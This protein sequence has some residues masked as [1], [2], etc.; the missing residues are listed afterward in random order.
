MAGPATG[1]GLGTPTSHGT[2]SRAGAPALQRRMTWDPVRGMTMAGPDDGP[3]SAAAPPFGAASSGPA[4][5]GSGGTA[6]TPTRPAIAPLVARSLDAAAP[7]VQ[8]EET[9][10]P[11][12]AAGATGATSASGGTTAAMPEAQL[13]DLARRLHEKIAARLSRDLLIERERSGALVDRG[14]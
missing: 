5:S 2:G 11:T 4:S 13:D 10:P 14:W 3:A 9:A 12:D 7:D 8:R 6:P 1:Q